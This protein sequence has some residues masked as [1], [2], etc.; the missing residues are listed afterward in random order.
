MS[1]VFFTMN[2]SPYSHFSSSFGLRLSCSSAWKW[3]VQTCTLM[4]FDCQFN[5]RLL[6]LHFSQLLFPGKFFSQEF[7]VC[8]FHSPLLLL[9]VQRLQ[10]DFVFKLFKGQA[11]SWK[12]EE[13]YEY[14]LTWSFTGPKSPILKTNC[15]N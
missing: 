4:L 10:G 15:E 11:H 6:K 13:K 8:D 7:V 14:K 9:V 1:V 5:F 2:A 12:D 3:N